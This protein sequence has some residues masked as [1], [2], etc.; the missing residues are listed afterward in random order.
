[1]RAHLAPGAELAFEVGYPDPDEIVATMGIERSS[2]HYRDGAGGPLLLHSGWYDAWDPG[3]RTL[4]FTLRV[5]EHRAGAPAREFLRRHRVHV[6]S[7]DE[8]DGPAGGV[9]PRGGRGD[10]RL[11]R[12]A[13]RARLRAPGL[14]VPGRR[15]SL[16]LRVCHLYP[17]EMNIYADRG[18]IAVLERRLAW[19]GHAIEVAGSGLGEPVDPGAHDLYY[20]GGGQDRDQAVVAEDLLRDQG[21]RAARGGGR[22]RRGPLR[23]RGLPARRATGTPAPTARACPGSGCWTSTPSRAPRA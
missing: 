11:R 7:P 20:L 17:G 13:A 23:L 1:M 14:P 4:E 12:H 15:V 16:T 5:E 19:R 2:G 8:V 18:N 3:T 10:G 9:R 22:R 6:F 21:R